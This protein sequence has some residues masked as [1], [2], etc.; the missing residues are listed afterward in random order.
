VTPEFIKDSFE[1][2][3]K[4]VPRHLKLLRIYFASLFVVVLAFTLF[5]AINA[6]LDHAYMT[7]ELTFGRL[8]FEQVSRFVSLS[9]TLISV[10]YSSTPLN[11]S[12]LIS[13]KNKE[14]ETAYQEMENLIPQF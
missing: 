1:A 13:L 6:T 7:K 11:A 8:M 5:I 10:T 9:T 4:K 2:R 3:V 12:S 14:I